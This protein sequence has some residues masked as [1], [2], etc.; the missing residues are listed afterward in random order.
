[1]VACGGAAPPTALA[2]PT[3]P[4][5]VA[6]T[7]TAVVMPA[8]PEARMLTME[9]PSKIRAGD[10]DV[11]Q[12]T[13]EVDDRGNITPTVSKEGNV[14]EGEV[15]E[16]PDVYKTHNVLAE[17]R[18]D[19]AGMEVRPG[20][21]VGQSLL[22]GEKVTF[23]WSVHPTEVGSYRGTLWFYLHFV[24]KEAGGMESRKAISAEQINIEA[25]TFF[26]LKANPARWLGVAGSFIGSVLGLPFLES[27][28][29]WLWNRLKRK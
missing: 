17:A 6:P 8:V 25:T 26:G 12:L 7:Q 27:I 9:Y 23:Y 18:L 11:V 22:P 5:V 21:T 10:S 1:M 3:Q 15:I 16:I 20:E 29:K 24:P 28:V 4:A 14:I 13:L 2:E 19:M